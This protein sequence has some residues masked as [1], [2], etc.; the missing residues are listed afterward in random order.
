MSEA[1]A[2]PKPS[3]RPIFGIAESLA[4]IEEVVG[5]AERTIR[6]FDISLSNRGFNSP[7][8]VDK[9]H[10]FLVAGRAHRILIALHNTDLLERESPRLLTLL[11]QF[12]MSIEIHRTPLDVALT[13][14]AA[15]G[16]HLSLRAHRV[17]V[18]IGPRLQFRW[19]LF[20]ETRVAIR[21]EPRLAPW[22]TVDQVAQV[23]S[24]ARAEIEAT[25]GIRRREGMSDAFDESCRSSSQVRRLANCE[26]V[27]ERFIH[28]SPTPAL[29]Q[30]RRPPDP[31][32]AK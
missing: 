14:S 18:R 23:R 19:Q 6:V 4:A 31:N 29:P 32:R 7:K 16:A 15:Q 13:A 9:L 20:E 8:L 26:P 17:T 3:Y 11:R 25:H 28:D 27:G 21:R 30:F 24:G 22:K 5:A 2:A 12:P 10:Q 1:E